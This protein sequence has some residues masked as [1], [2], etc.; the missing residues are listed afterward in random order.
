MPIML[1]FI[2]D[3]NATLTNMSHLRYTE[4]QNTRNKTVI[5][6]MP[7]L[8]HISYQSENISRIEQYPSHIYIK[9]NMSSPSVSN[10]VTK[11]D[12][13]IQTSPNTKYEVYL[14]SHSRLGNVIFQYASLYGIAQINGRQPVFV[15][16]EGNFKAFRLSF[17][18][19]YIPFLKSKLLPKDLP[20][21]QEKNSFVLENKFKELPTKDVVINGW[22]QTW[23]YFMP[24]FTCHLKS[25]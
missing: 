18:N 12:S 10:N 11:Y 21:V 17:A 23:R 15:P 6:L 4:H 1:S 16:H 2:A 13:Q 7:I 24:N 25:S 14:R 22:F 20:V 9:K 19:L 5:P 3:Y 8:K